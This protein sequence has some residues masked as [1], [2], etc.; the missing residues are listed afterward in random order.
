MYGCE[1]WTVAA[2][3]HRGGGCEAQ[4]QRL[5]G[6]GAAERSYPTPKVRSGS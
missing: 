3:W 6:T 1:N 5:H 2:A 4:G